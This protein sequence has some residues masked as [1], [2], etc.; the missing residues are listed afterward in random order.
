MSVATDAPEWCRT[1]AGRV[2]LPPGPRSEIEQ[3]A[4]TTCTDGDPL[5][6]LELGGRR[7]H[8][9]NHAQVFEEMEYDS[10]TMSEKERDRQREAQAAQL[11][12]MWQG[13]SV[14]ACV[15]SHAGDAIVH[16]RTFRG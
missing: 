8:V 4:G 9:M 10:W 11:R 7:D 13:R 3:L 15:A 14:L 5:R 12:E 16:G 2:Q 1:L 6:R